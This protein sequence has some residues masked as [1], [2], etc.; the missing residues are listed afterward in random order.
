MT[1]L[2]DIY[3]TDPDEWFEEV[4]RQARD[5][6]HE[7]RGA[8][9][10]ATS[11]QGLL[12]R[13]E[14]HLEP[15]VV[16]ADDPVHAEQI[17]AEIKYGEKLCIGVKHG[18][19][20]PLTYRD[21]GGYWWF[22]NAEPRRGDEPVDSLHDYIAERVVSAT[23]WGDE[24]LARRRVEEQ[25]RHRAIVEPYLE[26]LDEVLEGGATAGELREAFH[27]LI[28]GCLDPDSDVVV[29]DVSPDEHH[30]RIRLRD[31]GELFAEL[32][33]VDPGESAFADVVADELGLDDD[34]REAVAVVT[35]HRHFR[36]PALPQRDPV[37]LKRRAEKKEDAAAYYEAT[38]WVARNL[39]DVLEPPVDES[40]DDD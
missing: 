36:W 25:K 38:D 11:L 18:D 19:W 35:D 28:N 31:D 17:L 26:R 32:L 6:R 20:M 27:E 7:I 40:S 21:D 10:E 34:A 33:A 13:L 37:T 5:L 15:Y 24:A 9:D 23:N 2:P 14:P 29:A 22:D 3:E 4:Q 30:T 8:L 39:Q 1:R 16:D 12:D